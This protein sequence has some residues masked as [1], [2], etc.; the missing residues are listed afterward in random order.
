MLA[1]TTVMLVGYHFARLYLVSWI[2]GPKS[3]SIRDNVGISITPQQSDPNEDAAGLADHLNLFRSRVEEEGAKAGPGKGKRQRRK[4]D[5]IVHTFEE[6]DSVPGGIRFARSAGH[7]DD[8]GNGD[9]E[10]GRPLRSEQEK[11]GFD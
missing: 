7:N 1:I 3:R 9:E 4:P 6:D 8:D 5:P 10:D 11:E 2:K